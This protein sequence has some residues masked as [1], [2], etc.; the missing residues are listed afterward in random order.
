MFPQPLLSQRAFPVQ[1][2]LAGVLPVAYGALCGLALAHSKGLYAV[3]SLL[4]VLG[5]V[6]AGFDHSS[7]TSGARRGALGGSLF[8]LGIV[9]V[10][11]A[12]DK[13]VSSIPHPAIL[14]VV[15][16]TFAGIALGA[17]GGYFRGRIVA[18]AGA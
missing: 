10:H 5:G 15:V 13:A 4:S 2:V 3:L 1:V 6:G 14:L 11:A 17:V 8:G 16:T 9:L 12:T 18:P 7:A